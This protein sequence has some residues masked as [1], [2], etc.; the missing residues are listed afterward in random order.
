MTTGP[1]H[2]GR[3]GQ[4]KGVDYAVADLLASFMGVAGAFHLRY[5]AS[6]PVVEG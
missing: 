1:V 3:L 4:I 6:R 2:E 5:A